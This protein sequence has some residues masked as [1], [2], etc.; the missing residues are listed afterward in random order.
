MA[1]LPAAGEDEL[2]GGL[3]AGNQLA[4]PDQGQA[5]VG[6]EQLMRPEGFLGA[7]GVTEDL[8]VRAAWFAVCPARCRTAQ[9]NAAVK[10]RAFGR[11]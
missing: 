8:G 1:D 2:A 9:Q 11:G 6:R 5:Q 7:V 10:P 3:G 4:G